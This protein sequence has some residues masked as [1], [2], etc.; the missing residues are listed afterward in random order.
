M[1]QKCLCLEPVTADRAFV[2]VEHR[3]DLPGVALKSTMLEVSAETRDAAH[4]DEVQQALADHG[5]PV[6][7]A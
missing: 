7:R 4:S 3:C 5:F 2:D 6:T 1:V